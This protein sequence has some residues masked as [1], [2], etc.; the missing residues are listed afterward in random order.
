VEKLPPP[1]RKQ[2]V[3]ILDA[4]LGS[5]KAKNGLIIY[6]MRSLRLSGNSKQEQDN[7]SATTVGSLRVVSAFLAVKILASSA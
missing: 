7:M 3:K 4:F 5:E 6:E 1:K 2:I